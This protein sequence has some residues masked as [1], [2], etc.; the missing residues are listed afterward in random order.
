LSQRQSA[1]TKDIDQLSLVVQFVLLDSGKALL[2]KI[3]EG[4]KSK[5]TK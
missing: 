3:A 5:A 1:V 4:L 2:E